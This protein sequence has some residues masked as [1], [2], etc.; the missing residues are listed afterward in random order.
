[1]GSWEGTGTGSFQLGAQ[2]FAKLDE[3]Y[4]VYLPTANPSGDLDLSGASGSFSL[5]WYNPRSGSFEGDATTVTTGSSIAI[6]SPPSD[7]SS[8]WVVLLAR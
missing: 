6:G 2:V 4:A 8:D 3:V 1:M 5:R 7:A